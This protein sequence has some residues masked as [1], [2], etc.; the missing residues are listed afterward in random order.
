ML[1]VRLATLADV[2]ILVELMREFYAESGFP[3]DSDWAAGSFS[4]LIADPLRGAV[5]IGRWE[6]FGS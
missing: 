1:T 5:W 2:D 4:S 6:F 3:L